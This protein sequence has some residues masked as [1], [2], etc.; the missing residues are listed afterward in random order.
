[1]RRNIGL[2]ILFFGVLLALAISTLQPL[3]HRS[4]ANSGG[5]APPWELK[6]LDGEVVRSSAFQGKVVI[7]DFWAT[8][9]P[10]CKAEIPGFVQLQKDYGQRGLVI[11]GVSLDEKGPAIVKEFAAK[12]GI[13]YTLLMGNLELFREYGGSA[14]PTTIVINRQGNIV[15]KHVGFASKEVFEKEILPLL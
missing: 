9:C 13:N 12:F 15:A 7:L 5:L 11:V 3:F 8:W 2:G 10:P 6:N 4:I 14:I 1:M